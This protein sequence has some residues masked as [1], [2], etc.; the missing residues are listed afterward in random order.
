MPFVFGIVSGLASIPMR[1]AR[2]IGHKG[3]G[4]CRG[5][6]RSGRF[7]STLGLEIETIGISAVF[8]TCGSSDPQ[9]YNIGKI[10]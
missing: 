9:P 7:Y 6:V 1:M 8:S 4:Y 3:M 10:M 5:F 2:G